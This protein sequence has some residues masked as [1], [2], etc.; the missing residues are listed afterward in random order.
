V[1]EFL[2][3]FGFAAV[4]YFVYD[5]L[6]SKEL[7][8]RAGR[9]YCQRHDLQF[10]DETVALNKLGISRLE[11]G[12]LGFARH[13]TFEFCSD[14]S[15]RYHG[16]LEVRGAWVG[17]IKLEPYIDKRMFADTSVVINYDDTSA[18]PS[19]DDKAHRVELLKSSQ[20]Q[21]K[22]DRANID[23]NADSNTIDVNNINN[24]DK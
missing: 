20:P 8:V 15:H 13:Y 11:H 12:Y 21:G 17:N 18:D 6:R 19:A 5:G 10:L 3:L 16:K 7:A 23:K 4:V 14:G 1:A 24:V 2:V 9:R 22:T